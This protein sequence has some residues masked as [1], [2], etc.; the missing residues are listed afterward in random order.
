[1]IGVLVTLDNGKGTRWFRTTSFGHAASM[2][3]CEPGE[4]LSFRRMSELD[5]IR[6]E[7]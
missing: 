2:T 7:E 4:I 6:G 1:M 3:K 5:Y